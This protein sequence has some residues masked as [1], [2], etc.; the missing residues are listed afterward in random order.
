RDLASTQSFGAAYIPLSTV[1]EIQ[2]HTGPNQ[3]SR[4]NSK[5]RVVTTFNVRGRDMGSVVTEAQ[6]KIQERVNIPPGYWTD[7]GGEFKLMIEAAERLAIVVP[8]ALLIIFLFL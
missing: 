8:I 4:E 3:I 5:R 2:V 1:A 7:W 6:A